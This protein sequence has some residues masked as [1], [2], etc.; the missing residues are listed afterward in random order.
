MSFWKILLYNAI[1][2]AIWHVAAFLLCVYG[3]TSW[4]DFRRKRYQIFKWEKNGR[5]Y[6]KY[7]KIKLWKDLVPTHVGKD[8]F[9]KD[10]LKIEDLSLP[11]LDAF[12]LETCRGEWDHSLCALC[13]VPVVLLTPQPWGLLFGF[14]VLL[15]NLPFVAIQRYNRIRLLTLRKRRL[16]EMERC[17]ANA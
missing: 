12:L 3:N 14:L 1:F 9:S 11:Y 17:Q 16:R 6:V 10:H 7:L 2:I 5:W 4:F 13:A 15:G 8:G